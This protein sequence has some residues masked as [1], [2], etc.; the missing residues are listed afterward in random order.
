MRLRNGLVGGL[1]A[2]LALPAVL[3]AEPYVLDKEHA[4]LTFAVDHLGFSLVRGRF[5]DFDAEIDFDPKKPEAATISLTIKADSVISYSEARDKSVR[6]KSLLFVKKY[7]TITFVSKKLKLTSSNTAMV[8]GDL[9]L[10]GV[11][12]EE[13]FKAVMRRSAVNEL[14]KKK[15]AGFSVAGKIDRREYDMGWGVGA[16]GA[17]VEFGFDIEAYVEE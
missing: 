5:T 1:L 4:H 14:T 13:S 3:R 15:T 16:V 10:R 11:T 9:T 2:V 6:G 17:I 12:R 7:P 8:T